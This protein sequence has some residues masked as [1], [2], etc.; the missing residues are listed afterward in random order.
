MAPHEVLHARGQ[1]IDLLLHLRKPLVHV[2]SETTKL[3]MHSSKLCIRMFLK[4][5]KSRLR[6]SKPG[7]NKSFKR[8]EPLINGWRLSSGIPLGHIAPLSCPNVIRKSR[9]ISRHGRKF[10]LGDAVRVQV[11]RIN[12]FRSEIDFE[13]V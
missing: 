10:R 6:L 2:S 8:R 7:P 3:K 12:A 5:S 4:T 9:Q 13:L 1:P 11:A